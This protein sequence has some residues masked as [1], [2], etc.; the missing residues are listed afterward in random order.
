MPK[1]LATYRGRFIYI[2]NALMQF[3]TLETTHTTSEKEPIPLV[4]KHD[5]PKKHVFSPYIKTLGVTYPG[6]SNIENYPNR[7]G[8]L[9]AT[10]HYFINLR[11]VFC[12]LRYKLDS[13]TRVEFFIA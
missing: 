9:V 12:G 7:T 6:L 10:S 8:Y 13:I 3:L 2:K 4:Y 1:S 5:N 11:C